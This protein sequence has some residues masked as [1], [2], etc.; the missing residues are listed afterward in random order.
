MSDLNKDYDD[1]DLEADSAREEADD[2]ND[3]YGYDDPED[4]EEAAYDDVLK[5]MEK[6]N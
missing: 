2:I 5:L 3:L 4:N 1:E 6:D